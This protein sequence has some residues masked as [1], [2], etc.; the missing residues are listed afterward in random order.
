MN[1]KWFTLVELIVV[2]T[3][4]SVLWTIWFLSFWSYSSNA[5]DS[6]RISDLRSLEKALNIFYA[7]TSAY[8]MPDNSVEIRA[9][10]TVIRYQWEVGNTVL[11]Q[12]EISDAPTWWKD[13]LD[14]TYFTYSVNANRNQY[15]L[16]TFLESVSFN[17]P[18]IENVYAD[19]R[20]IKVHGKNLWIVLDGA[21]PVNKVTAIDTA[22]YLDIKNTT[23]SYTVYIGEDIEITGTWSRLISALGI[24]DS[25]ITSSDSTLVGYWD[26]SST[27][28]VNWV[29][30]LADLSQNDNHGTCYNSTST[31]VG[32]S[33]STSWPQIQN[34]KYMF[35][36]GVDDY[37]NM[38]TITSTSLNVTGSGLT[39]IAKIT[40]KNC[41]DRR[42]IVNL[43][44]SYLI[45][46]TGNDASTWI[47]FEWVGTSYWTDNFYTAGGAVALNSSN[48]V[49]LTFD[50]G[51]NAKIYVDGVLKATETPVTSIVA[52][53][54]P[55]IIGAEWPTCGWWWTNRFF[56]WN[57]DEIRIYNRAF[58][59]EE[60]SMISSFLE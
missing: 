7:K 13:P 37:I 43:R 23:S 52:P 51:V 29:K 59:A 39:I 28:V 12:I 14:A 20:Y 60:V 46:C 45:T 41:G 16:A 15:Q 10:S 34:G 49:I 3:I 55:F 40:P 53:S 18:F 35:F 17:H 56:S 26:M 36:D 47:N 27:V 19:T 5:R 21:L 11:R 8:P 58:S 54:C 38:G 32:C 30:K 22:G 9:G 6:T 2:I 50:P 24:A 42:W 44:H 57:I 25:T 33:E 48:V 4:L 1:K 31:I